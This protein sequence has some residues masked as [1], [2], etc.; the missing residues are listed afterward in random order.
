M[1]EI[2][3]I[4]LGLKSGTKWLD[5]YNSGLIWTTDFDLLTETQF[6]FYKNHIPTIDQFK[7]LYSFCK[8]NWSRMDG[9]VKQ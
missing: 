9:R 5:C 3:Y 8:I 7:E 2:E 1:R 4:D 6:S